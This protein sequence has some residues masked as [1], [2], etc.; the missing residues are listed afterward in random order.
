MNILEIDIVKENCY[1]KYPQISDVPR[2]ECEK[3]KI[4]GIPYGCKMVIE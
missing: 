4:R 1:N 2:E 3:C